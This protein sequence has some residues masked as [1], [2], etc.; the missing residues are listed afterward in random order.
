M[1]W[2]LYNQ[3]EAFSVPV[4]ALTALAVISSNDYVHLKTG[5]GLRKNLAI[6][7]NICTDNTKLT[8]REIINKYLQKS[9]RPKNT[10][11]DD[12]DIYTSDEDCVDNET[13][14]RFS[15]ASRYNTRS[16]K[17][18]VEPTIASEVKNQGIKHASCDGNIFI[19]QIIIICF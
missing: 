15:N 19:I 9:R 8:S 13:I 7:N 14:S 4:E 2:T 16:K 6:V 18:K 17:L 10:K 1:K 5:F 3:R 12:D 11:N